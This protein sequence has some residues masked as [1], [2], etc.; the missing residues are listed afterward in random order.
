[1]PGSPEQSR[2]LPTLVDPARFARQVVLEVDE[3]RRDPQAWAAYVAEAEGTSVLD[4][5]G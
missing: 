5:L 2:P 3:L 1:M 4:G